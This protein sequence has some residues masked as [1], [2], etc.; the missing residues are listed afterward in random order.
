M[1]YLNLINRTAEATAAAN[2]ELVAREAKLAI[3]SAILNCDKS[4]AKATAVFEQSQ[5]AIPYDPEK[6]F[7]YHLDLEILK[8]KLEFL[9]GQEREL[10]NDTIFD[11]EL[12]TLKPKS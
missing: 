12:P 4:I 2:N 10:F 1:K 5:C 11:E 6:S 7:S 9:K 3:Q 8:A